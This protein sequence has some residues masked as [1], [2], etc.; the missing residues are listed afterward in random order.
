MADNPPFEVVTFYN[1][2]TDEFCVEI[3]DNRPSGTGKEL[4]VIRMAD[5]DENPNDT[6]GLR[7]ENYAPELITQEYLDEVIMRNT[8]NWLS[9]TQ[10]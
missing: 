8:K 3:W 2:E 4:A 6:R 5:L 9:G 7:I 10:K 1:L